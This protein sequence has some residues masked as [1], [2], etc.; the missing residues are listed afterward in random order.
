MELL[1]RVRGDIRERL[2]RSRAAAEEYDRLERVL[3][4]LQGT[5]VTSERPKVAAPRLRRTTPARRRGRMRAPRGQNRERVLAA[6]TERPGAPVAEFAEVSGVQRPAIYALLS[7]LVSEGAVSERPL[8]SGGKAYEVT[9]APEPAI[10]S[11]ASAEASGEPL[12]EA[13]VDG[14]LEAARGSA[15]DNGQLEPGS[16][17]SSEGAGQDPAA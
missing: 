6:V 7:R 12:D 8:A 14:V 1:D 3:A 13:P 4:A 2:E 17:P 10:G 15:R 9:G 5:A 16:A 11:A